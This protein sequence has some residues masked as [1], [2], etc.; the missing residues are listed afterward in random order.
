MGHSEKPCSSDVASS[1]H[2]LEKRIADRSITVVINH[3]S[4]LPLKDKALRYFILTP[5]GE[6]ANGIA[7]VMAQEGYQNV[8]AAKETEL[9]DAVS[10]NILP[11]ATCSCSE[12][13]QPALRRLNR[14]GSLPPQPERV[15]TA[16]LI[17]AG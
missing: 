7:R 6:Q 9:S 8:V 14:M 4:L 2:K 10:G 12:P 3:H 17:R 15:M 11:A 1:A 5:W 13:S 16:A